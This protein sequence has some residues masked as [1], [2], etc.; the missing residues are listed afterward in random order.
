MSRILL[1]GT[2]YTLEKVAENLPVGS[3]VVTSRQK[4]KLEEFKKRGWITEKLDVSS[5]SELEEVLSRYPDL[6]CVLDSVP[7]PREG[8]PV[9]YQKNILACLKTLKNVKKI[10]YLST[11]GVYGVTDGSIVNEDTPC[12]P[13]TPNGKAR[14]EVE[15]L[16]LKSGY[17]VTLLRLPAIYGA[18]RGIAVSLA[19]GSYRLIE[20]GERFTNRIHVEDLANILLKA[21]SAENLP[22]ILCISDDAPTK[23]RDVVE[24]YCR[25]FDLPFPESI[26]LEQAKQAGLYTMIGNQQV[27]NSLMKKVLQIELKYPSYKA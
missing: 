21:I 6:T 11:T 16:Y 22:K 17:P 24:F 18:D 12:N 3:F 1:L 13:E 2:G 7:P 5:I 26:T 4:Q 25:K 8:D 23:A 19:K 10:V 20:G 9:M 15:T 27:D 14:F